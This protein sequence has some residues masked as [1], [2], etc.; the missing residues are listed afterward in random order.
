[1]IL[2]LISGFPLDS[3]MQ[4]DTSYVYHKH[5]KHIIVIITQLP[6]DAIT[7]I[8]KSNYVKKQMVTIWGLYTEN[9]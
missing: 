6:T 8:L 5:S 3:P 9:L 7:M 2:K 1:M 4:R